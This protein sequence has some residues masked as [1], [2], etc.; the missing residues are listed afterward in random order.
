MV[1]L[2]QNEKD[3]HVKLDIIPNLFRLTENF[4]NKDKLC[5]NNRRENEMKIIDFPLKSVLI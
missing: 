3:F 1:F 5:D 2:C 4:T